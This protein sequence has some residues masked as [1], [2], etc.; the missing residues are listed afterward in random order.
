MT[1]N[2][3]TVSNEQSSDNGEMMEE[4]KDAKAYDNKTRK[5]ERENI[6]T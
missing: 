4:L 6:K 1:E 3:V 5:I 2:L